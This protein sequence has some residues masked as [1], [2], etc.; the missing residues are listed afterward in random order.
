M[1][2]FIDGIYLNEQKGQIGTGNTA[3][4]VAYKNYYAARLAGD[5][6]DAYLL[7]DDMALTGL[8]EQIPLASFLRKFIHQPNLQPQ[9]EELLPRLGPAPKTA[10]PSKADPP[11]IK[12]AAQAAKAQKPAP[13]QKKQSGWTKAGEQAQDK[14]WWE[15]TSLGADSLIKKK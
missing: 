4:Q 14:P 15:M 5:K 1:T 6:V 3:S 12:P 7:S 13:A 8:R 11:P 9:F 10:Q 2:A